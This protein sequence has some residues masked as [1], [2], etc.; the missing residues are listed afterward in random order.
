MTNIVY[1]AKR[2][3]EHFLDEV[4]VGEESIPMDRHC[5]LPQHH[6]GP[7]S[8]ITSKRAMA[9]RKAWEEANPDDIDKRR[10]SDIVV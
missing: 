2:C 4:M 9:E 10:G 3:R 6:V 5:D 1:E 8:S 7:H